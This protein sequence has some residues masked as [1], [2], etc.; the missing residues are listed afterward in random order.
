MFENESDWREHTGPVG[1]EPPTKEELAKKK[2]AEAQARRAYPY[3]K[4]VE[5]GEGKKKPTDPSLIDKET[6][7]ILNSLH[8]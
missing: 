3:G 2:A 8:D 5:K 4:P 1:V 6:G 7:K